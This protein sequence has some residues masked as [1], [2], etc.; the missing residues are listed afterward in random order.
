M[1]LLSPPL[2]V[3]APAPPLSV[4]A[5]ALPLMVSFWLEPVRVSPP[6][7]PLIVIVSVPAVQEVKLTALRSTDA[8]LTISAFAFA[9]PKIVAILPVPT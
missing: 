8:P 7:V 9:S 5:P 2:S 6:A 1:S 3:S 4:S